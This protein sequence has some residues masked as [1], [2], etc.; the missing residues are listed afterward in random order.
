MSAH[1]KDAGAK[2]GF[3][4]D[5][6][7]AEEGLPSSDAPLRLAEDY[8]APDWERYEFL[9]PLGQ[10]G[11]G[12]VYQ[13]RDRRLGRVVALK[14]LHSDDPHMVKRFQQEARAQ[15]RIDHPHICRVFEVGEAAGRAYI[16]MQYV[17]GR[18]LDAIA[19]ELSLLEKVQIIHDVAEALHEAHRQGVIHRDIKPSDGLHLATARVYQPA[20]SV[21]LKGPR[22]P[23]ALHAPEQLGNSQAGHHLKCR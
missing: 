7:L 14:F 16:A 12:A 9:C 15:A 13:A 6:T 17:A 2:A 19:A 20:Q 1:Q 10:G 22:Y 21:R 18:S 3:A 4:T 11:M 8:P 23:A 5:E